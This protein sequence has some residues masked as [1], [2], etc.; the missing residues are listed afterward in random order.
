[1][2]G[3]GHWPWNAGFPAISIASGDAGGKFTCVGLYGVYTMS[4]KEVVVDAVDASAPLI[5]PK[6]R[7]VVKTAKVFFIFLASID[8]HKVAVFFQISLLYLII[9]YA[10]K[11]VKGVDNECRRTRIK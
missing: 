11:S 5:T 7:S 2:S 8:R 6:S 4:N 1:V 3:K 10:V 9:A